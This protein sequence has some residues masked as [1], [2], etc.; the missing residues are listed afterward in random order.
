VGRRTLSLSMPAPLVRLGARAD[1]TLRRGKAKLTP[2]RAAY[3][4]HPDWVVSTG[5]A[6]PPSLWR[7]EVE[8]EQGLADTA[9]WYRAEGWL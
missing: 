6:P 3:F 9:A 4:C 1:R 5:R 8:T 2:D 7:P